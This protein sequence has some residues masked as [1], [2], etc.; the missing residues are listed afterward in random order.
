MSLRG[1]NYLRLE[2]DPLDGDED[3]GE[4]LRLGHVERPLLHQPLARLRVSRSLPTHLMGW[5]WGGG[6]VVRWGRTS[7]KK[8]N[9]R[10]RGRTRSFRYIVVSFRTK[11]TLETEL[12][13]NTRRTDCR[14]TSACR[15]GIGSELVH[16]VPDPK[17]PYLI[18]VKQPFSE[19][20]TT[21]STSDRTTESRSPRMPE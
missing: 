12:F 18:D 19:P 17:P 21:R 6:E 8:G 14:V 15:D 1:V 20:Y 7:Q 10:R 3:L 9:A 16:P 2:V 4:A 11:I 13:I 5:G